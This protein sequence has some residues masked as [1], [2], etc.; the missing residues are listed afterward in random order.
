MVPVSLR[1]FNEISI[2]AGIDVVDIYCLMC[3]LCTDSTAYVYQLAALYSVL[4]NTKMLIS[5]YGVRHPD[6]RHKSKL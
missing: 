5:S 1:S 4:L 2:M 6:R 3:A